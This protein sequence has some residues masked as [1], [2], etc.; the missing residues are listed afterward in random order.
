MDND[1]AE[2]RRVIVP[3]MAQYVIIMICELSEL[4]SILAAAAAA[5]KGET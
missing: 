3:Y 4:V 1:L 5:E 2:Q